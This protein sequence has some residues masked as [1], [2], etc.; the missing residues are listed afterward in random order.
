[1]TPATALITL[2]RTL[3]ASPYLSLLLHEDFSCSDST[4]GPMWSPTKI[5]QVLH[6]LKPINKPRLK[7]G[8]PILVRLYLYL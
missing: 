3:E 1:M 7:E 6:V 8:Y 2:S 5:L 4:S